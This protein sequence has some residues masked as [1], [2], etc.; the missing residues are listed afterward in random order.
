MLQ[1]VVP[2]AS[3]RADKGVFPDTM[4]MVGNVLSQL[5]VAG[6]VDERSGAVS[7]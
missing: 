1:H 7:R 5:V 4:A 3:S 6:E 2:F